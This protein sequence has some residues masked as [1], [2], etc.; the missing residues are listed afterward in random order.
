[1]ERSVLLSETA[2]QPGRVRGAD[3]HVPREHS[4]DA[5]SYGTQTLRPVATLDTFTD[6]ER[7]LARIKSQT[8]VSGSRLEGGR[9]VW[10][11]CQP[12]HRAV[13]G[14][15]LSMAQRLVPAPRDLSIYMTNRHATILFGAEAE[16]L[17]LSMGGERHGSFVS[18]EIDGFFVRAHVPDEA[19]DEAF[20]ANFVHAH[21]QLREVA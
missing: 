11:H 13:M 3:L 9:V 1:M 7:Q 15:A 6:C 5:E 12:R 4:P 20:A 10:A 14:H 17:L 8:R 19:Q 2:A 18:V 21:S 16:E